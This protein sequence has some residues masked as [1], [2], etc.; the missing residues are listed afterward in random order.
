MEAEDA[1]L[2]V[3][4]GDIAYPVSSD[5]ALEELYFGTYRGLMA[6]TPFYPC[7][8]NH[9]YID[10]LAPYLRWHALPNAQG[11]VA[12]HE[13]RYYRFEAKGVEFLSLDSNE[14]LWEG[15]AMLDWLDARLAASRAF[16]RIV[17]FHHPPYT[18]GKHATD[19]TC[20][21]A[22]ERLAPRLERARIPL[23]LNGHDHNY[24][25]SLSGDTTYLV[26]GGGGAWL[27]EA[28]A[29][30]RLQMS[31]NWHHYLRALVDG[32]KMRVEAVG[33]DGS[34][35]DQ[36][37]LRPGPTLRSAVNAAGFEA[38]LAPGALAS[39]F[40]YHLAAKGMADIRVSMDGEALPVLG[41][42]GGQLNVLIPSGRTGRR[43]MKIETPNGAAI[44]E[45]E[46][47]RAAPALFRDAAGRPL[48]S[49]PGSV[50]AKV[51]LY[52][53]GSG[54]EKVRLRSGLKDLGTYIAA[55]AAG[56][57]GVEEIEVVLGVGW[58]DLR[59]EAAI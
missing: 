54:G 41:A 44:L 35:L 18:G 49:S 8:G 12:A 11:T 21:L 10:N 40:G 58:E 53:T 28:G 52:L 20:K 38:R 24:Q 57:A 26:T 31:G 45:I 42:S 48:T 4:T 23:V 7:P 33:L 15:K 6:R 32:W 19:E 25:R 36:T 3:H 46:V 14:P 2:L 30:E 13:G 27:Y 5:A 47:V 16:W 37:E 29:H 34:V 51:K 39:V 55:P 1:D 50:G 59:A 56:L 9:D 22:A 17:Y 43:V